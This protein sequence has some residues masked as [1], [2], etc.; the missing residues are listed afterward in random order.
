MIV[1]RRWM[2]DMR[3]LRLIKN[4]IITTV[5][6]LGFV[7]GCSPSPPSDQQTFIENLNQHRSAWSSA[8]RAGNG[9]AE[10]N[11]IEKG[12]RVLSR[13]E[14]KRIRAWIGKVES[15]E[16]WLVEVRYEGCEFEL[17][18]ASSS[19]S[20]L[21]GLRK[22][23]WIVFNGTVDKEKSWT[24]SGAMELPEIVVSNASFRKPE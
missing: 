6:V 13:L 16:S 12:Q 19:E 24:G 2:K 20:E 9:V 5:S 1:A 23:D 18:P 4:I 21:P 17:S 8:D 10:N 22:G 11:A 14:G 15:V 3:N 7:L